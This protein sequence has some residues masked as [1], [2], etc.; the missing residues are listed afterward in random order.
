MVLHVSVFKN[1]F[2]M[3]KNFLNVGTFP[4]FELLGWELFQVGTS[5]WEHF[6][7]GILPGGN[8]SVHRLLSP[9]LY[10]YLFWSPFVLHKYL[11]RR[12]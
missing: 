3:K 2:C 1:K 4:P 12:D 7:V 9:L 5:G 10:A 11:F 8:F 6:R